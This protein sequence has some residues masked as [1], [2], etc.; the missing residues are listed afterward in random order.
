MPRWDYDFCQFRRTMPD[1]NHDNEK[2]RLAEL[3]AR[4]A[5]SE[6][7]LLAR[8][9]RSLSPEGRETLENEFRR[10]DLTPELDLFAPDIGEDI[11]EWDDLVIVHRYRDLP[12]ALLAKGSL[13]SAGIEFLVDDNM[14]RTDWFIS[15]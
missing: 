7:Q 14:G 12:E 2:Q 15:N 5:D 1:I 4:L 11:L 6:L 3:Y 9:F 13:E 8:D 10:R